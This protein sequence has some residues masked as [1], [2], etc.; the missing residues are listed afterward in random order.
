MMLFLALRSVRLCKAGQSL[1]GPTYDES[2]AEKFGVY[3]PFTWPPRENGAPKTGQ[4]GLLLQR[5]LKVLGQGF[6]VRWAPVATM[7]LLAALL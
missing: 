3:C 1:D 5:Y 2:I 6:R 4:I 7:C